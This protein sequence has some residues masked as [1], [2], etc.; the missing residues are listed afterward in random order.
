MKKWLALLMALLLLAS[1]AYAEA[2]EREIEIEGMAEVIAEARAEGDGYAIYYDVDRFVF[3][4]NGMGDGIDVLV[5]ASDAAVSPVYM[6]I[7]AV[8]TDAA[9]AYLDDGFDDA[10]EVV[11]GAAELPA[12]L[13]TAKRSEVLYATYIVEAGDKSFALDLAYASEAAEGFG[14]RL[15]AVVDTFELVDA[16]DI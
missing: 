5:P 1:S 11:V 2:R 3:H 12:R 8:D 7:R 6:Q 13:L 4:P 10:G 15:L 16:A 9:Q 14:A